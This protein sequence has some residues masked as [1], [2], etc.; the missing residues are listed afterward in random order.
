MDRALRWGTALI[1]LA[2]AM[3]VGAQEMPAV[4]APGQATVSAPAARGTGTVRGRVLNTATGTYVANAEVRVE[5][6]GLSTYTGRGGDYALLN[7]PA[8]TAS[9]AV[10][11]AGLE[12]T[13]ATVAVAAGQAATLDVQLKARSLGG[14]GEADRDTIVVT[15]QRS[16]EAAALMKR[17]SSLNAV[18]AVDADNFGALTM[19]D[20][21]EFLK[22][23]PG[24]SIDYVEVDTNAVRIGGLDPKYSIFTTDG[25]RMATATSNNNAGRQNS[26]EQMSSPVSRA[27]SSTTR[28]SPAWTPTRRAGR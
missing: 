25:A 2:S 8:G 16:G 17:R 5:G 4:P 24:I 12:E 15:G 27:S 18:T 1:A 3:P 28:C 23:M 11:Y 19:G 13:V 7:V 20:V 21:G 26:F 6:T 9:I 10:S 14:A 22:N